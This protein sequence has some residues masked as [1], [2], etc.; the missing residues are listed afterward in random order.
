LGELAI[1]HF[2]Q[3]SPRTLVKFIEHFEDG[4][5]K[6]PLCKRGEEHARLYAQLLG[7]GVK[8]DLVPLIIAFFF[9]FFYSKCAINIHFLYHPE[10]GVGGTTFM[11][12]C[13]SSL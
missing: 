12:S 2:T 6:H 7:F 8:F 3:C 1:I 11:K 4:K 9:F 5:V 13:C 10:L